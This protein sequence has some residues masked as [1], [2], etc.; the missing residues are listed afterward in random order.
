MVSL[1][2]TAIVYS[3]INV[4]RNIYV[5]VDITSYPEHWSMMFFQGIYDVNTNSVES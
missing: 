4:A 1:A 2:T 5:D 3:Y